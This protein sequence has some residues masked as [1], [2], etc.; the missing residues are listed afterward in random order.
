MITNLFLYT[1]ILSIYILYFLYETPFVIT[2]YQ[3]VRIGRYN[4]KIN[5]IYCKIFK[6]YKKLIDYNLIV[7]TQQPSSK[8]S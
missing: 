6:K 3:Q 1:Y 2:Y 8:K 4:L 5:H 7:L